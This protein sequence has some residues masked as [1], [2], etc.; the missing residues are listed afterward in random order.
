MKNPA[1]NILVPYDSVLF[2]AKDLHEIYVKQRNSMKFPTANSHIELARW[3]VTN[4]LYDEA[5]TE[6]RDAIRLEPKRTEPQLM[7][8]RLTQPSANNQLTVEEKIKEAILKK[9]LSQSEE[10]TSLTGISREQSAIFVRKIQPILLNKCGNANCHGSAA[11]SEFRLTQ[12]SRRY[13]NH[14]IYAEKNLAEVMKWIDLDEVARSQLLVKPEQEHP[15]QGMVVFSGY[16]GRKQ[17]QLIQKWVGEVVADRLKQDQLR[18]DRL[19]RRAQRRKGQARENLLE[20][21]AAIQSKSDV[22]Q[23]AMEV[24]PVLLKGDIS[25]ISGFEP[26]KLSDQQINELVKEKPTDPF[27]PALFNSALPPEKP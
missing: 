15:Q 7:L 2:E 22:Q 17:R 11:K 6:L 21:A 14:R 24:D 10:A 23:A 4:Q 19:T 9:Q 18:A 3:C 27:D 8:R 13:G 20:Q 12:V 16:A 1:G 25:L 26:K 5:K